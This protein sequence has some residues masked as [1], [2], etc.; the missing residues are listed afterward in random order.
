MPS[1]LRREKPP[2]RAEKPRA[3]E[4]CIWPA[5]EP[6]TT[7]SLR[8]DCSFRSIE[9]IEPVRLRF[10]TMSVEATAVP[11]VKWTESQATRPATTMP[12]A[13]GSVNLPYRLSAAR[14]HPLHS[15]TR[16]LPRIFEP[17]LFLNMGAMGFDRLWTE[18]QR[19]GN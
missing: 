17:K 6:Q 3:R 10:I 4:S 14:A 19:L 5:G 8:F 9:Q 13:D 2:H 11:A 18:M 16:D 1:K 15:I 12:V 7:I